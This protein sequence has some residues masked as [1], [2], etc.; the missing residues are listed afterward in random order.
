MKKGVLLGNRGKDNDK[1]S[2]G[3]EKKA[4]TS[5]EKK[6]LEI[7]KRNAIKCEVDKSEEKC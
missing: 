5:Q 2:G 3:K 4:K 7:K 1:N 6:K